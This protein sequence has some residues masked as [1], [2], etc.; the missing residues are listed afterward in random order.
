MGHTCVFAGLPLVKLRAT[1]TLDEIDTAQGLNDST[2]TGLRLMG[3]PIG[4]TIAFS[5]NGPGRAA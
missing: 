2:A 4:R 5:L 1:G 3:G